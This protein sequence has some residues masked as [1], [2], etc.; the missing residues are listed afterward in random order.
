MME[1][2]DL[3]RY[4]LSEI[5]HHIGGEIEDTGYLKYLNSRRTAILSDLIDINYRLE[6]CIEASIRH[7]ENATRMKDA[8]PHADTKTIEQLMADHGV[9]L[10]QAEMLKRKKVMEN[11]RAETKKRH[12]KVCKALQRGLSNAEVSRMFNYHPSTVT[13]IWQRYNKDRQ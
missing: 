13:R 4:K 2:N 10:Y 6:K 9:S 11:R 1:S 8:K 3:Q 12:L 7:K 5:L